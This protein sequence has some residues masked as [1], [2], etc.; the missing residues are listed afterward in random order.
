MSAFFTGVVA[1]LAPSAIAFG[2]MIWAGGVGEDPDETTCQVVPFVRKQ[3][4]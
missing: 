2:W 3:T 1:V 4:K